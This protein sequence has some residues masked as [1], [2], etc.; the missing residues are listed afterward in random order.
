MGFSLFDLGWAAGENPPVPA[1]MFGG[2]DTIVDTV[3][4][5]GKGRMMRP[6]TRRAS[7]RP[8]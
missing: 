2:W 7:D 3:N 5:S 8:R 4:L 1:K 6:L